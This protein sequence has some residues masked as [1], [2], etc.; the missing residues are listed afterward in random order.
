LSLHHSAK[1]PAVIS[2]PL[3]T[4]MAFGTPRSDLMR[5]RTRTSRVA[6]IDVSTTEMVN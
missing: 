6:V 2:G 3:S 1:T 5:S 4:L